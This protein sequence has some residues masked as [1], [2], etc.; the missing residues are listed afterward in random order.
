LHNSNTLEHN[1]E[2]TS[3]TNIYGG[4]PSKGDERSTIAYSRERAQTAEG[5]KRRATKLES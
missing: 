5:G 1:F 3:I 4:M 2:D